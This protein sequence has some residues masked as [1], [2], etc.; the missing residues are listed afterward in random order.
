MNFHEAFSTSS[1]VDDDEPLA[2]TVVPLGELEHG[3]H[4][5][6]CDPLTSRPGPGF[7]RPIPPGHHPVDVLVNGDA[8]VAL[9]RITFAAGAPVRWELA[10][11]EGQD[12]RTLAE[13]EGF[14]HGV[15][16]GTSCFAEPGA[17]IDRQALLRDLDAPVF[18]AV[19]P[20]MIAFRSGYGDG[21]Y[22]S[23]FGL[24]TEDRPLCLVTD[25]G[26]GEFEQP[27]FHRDEGY[28]RQRAL[29]IAGQL[30][31]AVAAI[32]H[33]DGAEDDLASD[34][35]A[36]EADGA[37]ALPAVFDLLRAHGDQ[38]WARDTLI[39]I[40]CV[41]GWYPEGQAALV[42]WLPDARTEELGQLFERSS[43]PSPPPR[44]SPATIAALDRCAVR[45]ALEREIVRLASDAVRTNPEVV[46]LLRRA[47]DA[48]SAPIAV[49]ALGGLAKVGRLEP[50]AVARGL[51][52][53]ADTDDP[54]DAQLAARALYAGGALEALGACLRSERPSTRL[55]AARVLVNDGPYQPE[56][57]AVGQALVRD[58]ALPLEV[59]FEAVST[60]GHDTWIEAYEILGRA[61]HGEAPL[62][63]GYQGGPLAL[64]ALD[65]LRSTGGTPRVR[66]E[67][68]RLA[69]RI[70]A[71]SA[72]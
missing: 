22:S 64:A 59:R 69:R 31:A 44:L 72:S 24:D 38:S 45:P 48:G 56:V 10:V 34:L 51:V 29:A 26:I 49:D 1:L 40:A 46:P 7:V 36:L 54:D 63:L 14:G 70:R 47:L 57:H 20:G 3:E 32:L 37:V 17:E 13:G 66:T 23:F 19:G 16:S 21:I 27:T 15:D 25:F 43:L 61:G 68:D 71:R 11:L 30:P 33:D 58:E 60:C 50:D 55:A 18:H 42:D 4:V 12:V 2:C 65:R 28:R 5:A 39:G 9:A 35:C 53:L 8:R 52:L 67:A 41:L 62:Q 6:A